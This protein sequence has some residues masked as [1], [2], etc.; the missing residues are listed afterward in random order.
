MRGGDRERKR[1]KARIFMRK[2]SDLANNYFILDLI[3]M[4]GSK[5]C[6]LMLMMGSSINHLSQ[7]TTEHSLKHDLP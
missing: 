6:H 7:K 1:T 3:M 4:V 2:K 5:K